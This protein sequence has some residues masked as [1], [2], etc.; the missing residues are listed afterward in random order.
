[1]DGLITIVDAAALDQYREIINSIA[2]LELR[3]LGKFV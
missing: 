1:V 3:G 2:T